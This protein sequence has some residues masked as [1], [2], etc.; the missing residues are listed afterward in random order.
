MGLGVKIEKYL[1]RAILWLW[2][3][4]GVLISQ[5][6]DSFTFDIFDKDIT[7]D[8]LHTQAEG[9]VEIIVRITQL[10]EDSLGFQMN[11]GGT[12]EVVDLAREK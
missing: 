11:R 5:R 10:T 8:V 2:E 3:K 12:I 4:A 7:D 1:E 6:A 9:G